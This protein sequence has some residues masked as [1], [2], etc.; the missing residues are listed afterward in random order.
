MAD[1]KKTQAQKDELR[2][3]LDEKRAEEKRVESDAKA[4]KNPEWDKKRHLDP[5]RD[6]RREHKSGEAKDAEGQS[7]RGHI[8]Q[9]ATS[10]GYTSTK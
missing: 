9:T 6:P 5:L 4:E 10:K 3:Y 2:D 7:R 8:D 1:D